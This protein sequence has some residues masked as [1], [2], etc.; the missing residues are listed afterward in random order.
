MD[1]AKAIERNRDALLRVLAAL[2]AM[3]GLAPG[4]DAS[5]LAATRL[6]R[7]MRSRL[8]KVLRPAESALRRLIVIAAHE[9]AR[10]GR[11]VS[12]APMRPA[13]IAPIPK[14]E[15]SHVPAFPLADKLKRF[16]VRRHPG[17]GALP[18]I[19]VPGY[20]DPVFPKT[21]LASPEDIL[22]CGRLALRLETLHRALNDLPRQAKRFARWQARRD[23]KQIPDWLSPI[24]PGRPPGNRQRPTHE[25][26]HILRACHALAN[27]ALKPPDISFGDAA[28]HGV[29]WQDT[30]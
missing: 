28:F 10:D 25:V 30:S 6:T 9:M 4:R 27:E 26:D 24:R 3:A 19:C 15:S 29:A 23:E 8:L 17:A 16:D 20:T 2:F 21:P 1:W 11:A 12:T 14:G 13:P 7:R 22:D 5:A 18:R